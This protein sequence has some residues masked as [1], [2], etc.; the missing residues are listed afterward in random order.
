MSSICCPQQLI[1]DFR[2]DGPDEGL[3][4]Q[5]RLPQ[6]RR[7]VDQRQSMRLSV[8]L[9]GASTPCLEE[10]GEHRAGDRW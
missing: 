7:A 3:G 10:G 9:L 6:V 4:S 5:L 1:N 8:R 2:V